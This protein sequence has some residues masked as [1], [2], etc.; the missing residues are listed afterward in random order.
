M[1]LVPDLQMCCIDHSITALKC[2][3]CWHVTLNGMVV[4]T[5]KDNHTRDFKCHFV[6]IMLHKP[7]VAANIYPIFAWEDDM[8]RTFQFYSI[9]FAKFF[10]FC[11]HPCF[12]DFC[13]KQNLTTGRPLQ[14]HHNGHDGVSNHQ[15][16]ECLLTVYP[17]CRSKKASKHRVTGLCE[18]NSPVTGEFPTQRTSDAENVSIIWWR[19]HATT[20]ASYADN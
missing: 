12:R 9:I 3:Q 7:T 8:V 19:H 2:R 5:N 13:N 11:S 6:Y 17:R 14:W 10:S 15:P 4:L 1:A 18:G 16:Y 20:R